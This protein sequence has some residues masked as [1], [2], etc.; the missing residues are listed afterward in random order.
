[1]PLHLAS[2]HSFIEV[3]LAVLWWAIYGDRLQYA[4]L[5]YSGL[6]SLALGFSDVPSLLESWV[7]PEP[8][9]VHKQSMVLC[10]EGD[11][12][13]Q[14]SMVNTGQTPYFWTQQAILCLVVAHTLDSQTTS[15]YTTTQLSSALVYL[16]LQQ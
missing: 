9:S 1:M 5:L 7:G 13:S 10:R 4:R 6:A 16:Q 15:V 14:E 8:P 12:D 11:S 2:L 3:D